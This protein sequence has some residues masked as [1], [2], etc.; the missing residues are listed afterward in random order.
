MT[1]KSR[2]K[3]IS[4][5]KQKEYTS[6]KAGTAVLKAKQSTEKAKT[7]GTERY[8][9]VIQSKKQEATT[10]TKCFHIYTPPNITSSDINIYKLNYIQP[11]CLQCSRK[12]TCF[13]TW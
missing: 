5:K 12:A 3:E 10:K 8:T 2:R 7:K 13:S 4:T 6:K 11:R 1:Q 9:Q